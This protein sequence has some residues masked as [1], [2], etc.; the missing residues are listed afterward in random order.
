MSSTYFNARRGWSSSK[1]V[2]TTDSC[3]IE[4]L[5][6]CGWIGNLDAVEN[7][8]SSISP[9]Y[10]ASGLSTMG[11]ARGG[12]LARTESDPARVADAAL[13]TK[14]AAPA[15]DTAMADHRSMR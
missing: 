6:K 3:A 4:R 1:H 11:L 5:V 8:M 2:A 13:A 12:S 14:N 10:G 9:R 7:A 15:S